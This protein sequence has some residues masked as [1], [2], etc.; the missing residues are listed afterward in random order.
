[1]NNK[2]SKGP[3]FDP[4]GILE[5]ANSWDDKLPLY[6]NDVWLKYELKNYNEFLLK[7]NWKV[8]EGRKEKLSILKIKW[9]GGLLRFTL[10]T[11]PLNAEYFYFVQ[12]QAILYE[13]LYITLCFPFLHLLVFIS[14]SEVT[15]NE[16]K[17]YKNGKTFSG[18]INFL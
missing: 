4:C 12:A 10:F 2:N 9:D 15:R 16:R 5:L 14:L 18:M 8:M 17:L 11:I 1:M 7:P 13:T 3:K 6:L